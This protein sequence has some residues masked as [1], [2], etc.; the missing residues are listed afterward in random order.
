MPFD[1]ELL[2]KNKDI[3]IDNL[4]NIT[5]N[6]SKIKNKILNISKSIRK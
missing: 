6:L 4:N 5:I 2:V 3:I 1:Y